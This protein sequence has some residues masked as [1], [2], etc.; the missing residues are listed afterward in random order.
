MRGET[1]W[2]AVWPVATAGGAFAVVYVVT[3]AS[4]A[5]VETVLFRSVAALVAVGVVSLALQVVLGAARRDPEP[6]SAIID[7]TLPEEGPD[8]IEAP[9]VALLSDEADEERAAARR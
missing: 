5:A 3:L 4:G 9:G 1:D 8:V 6:P 2:F 7:I